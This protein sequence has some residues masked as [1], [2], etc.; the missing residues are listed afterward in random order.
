MAELSTLARPYAKAAFNVASEQN[1]L[2]N[3]SAMLSTL[4]AVTLEQNVA[5][6][7]SNPSLTSA[8]KANFVTNLCA[9]DLNDAGKQFVNTLADNHRL[10]LLA[11][12]FNQFQV[13]KSELEKSVDVTVTSAF[14]LSDTQ[15]NTLSEKLA[16]KLGR[17]VSITTVVD[18]SIIGG[19]IIR[20]DDFVIDGS[21]SGKLAKMAEA[22]N[23]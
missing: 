7:L 16:A 20:A 6:V 1:G 3:W 11:E 8:D 4:A 21:V 23:S 15:Q 2:A 12:I 10:P 17:D 9:D 18:N 13:L 14:E 19:V 5:T 22:M